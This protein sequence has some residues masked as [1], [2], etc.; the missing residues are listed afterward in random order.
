[1]FCDENVESLM[2][3]SVVSRLDEMYEA[4][5]MGDQ[6]GFYIIIIIIEWL[7]DSDRL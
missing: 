1:M 5:K 7:H 6:I 3:L 2:S 4:A